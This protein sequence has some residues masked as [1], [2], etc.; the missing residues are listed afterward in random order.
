MRTS[1]LCRLFFWCDP[2][3]CLRYPLGRRKAQ[4]SA[5]QHGFKLHLAIN[6]KGEL[7]NVTLTT[8]NIDD[9]KPVRELLTPLFFIEDEVTTQ[10]LFYLGKYRPLLSLGRAWA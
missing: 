7:L 9:R 5:H 10:L 3:L 8:G 2:A 4:G 6:H 1:P